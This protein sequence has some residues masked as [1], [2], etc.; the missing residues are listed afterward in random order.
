[1]SGLRYEHSNL[2]PRVCLSSFNENIILKP[3]EWHN[4]I[5]QAPRIISYFNKDSSPASCSRRSSL[6]VNVSLENHELLF[7]KTEKELIIRS[8]ETFMLVRLSKGEYERMVEIAPLTTGHVVKISSKASFANYELNRIV[9][10]VSANIQKL[11]KE[12][13]DL[14][15]TC[16][17]LD[18][19]S[20]IHPPPPVGQKEILGEINKFDQESKLVSQLIRVYSSL[21]VHLV[22]SNSEYVF[23]I[24][25]I[26]N[27]K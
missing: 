23:N 19:E 6:D 22:E 7:A 26:P 21:I 16:G 18:I 1:M 15:K 12:A 27:S 25:K 17:E 24:W 2:V 20:V 10:T 14:Y 11:V 9:T 4:L 8:K 3:D 5:L 13:Y